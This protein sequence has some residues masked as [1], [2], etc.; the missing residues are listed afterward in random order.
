M[1]AF[2]G[3]WS[4]PYIS[5][6]DSYECRVASTLS[7]SS[8]LNSMRSVH[9]GTRTWKSTCTHHHIYVYIYTL[10]SVESLSVTKLYNMSHK[11]KICTSCFVEPI[12]SHVQ[13]Y[14]EFWVN[15]YVQFF[16]ILTLQLNKLRFGFVRSIKQRLSKWHDWT[17]VV[18]KLYLRSNWLGLP[19]L[20]VS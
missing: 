12:S 4:E 9:A 3:L 7:V 17:Q 18:K 16:K 15:I 1:C 14:V 5:S 8:I 11:W 19:S 10:T 2:T 20:I 13:F 6:I